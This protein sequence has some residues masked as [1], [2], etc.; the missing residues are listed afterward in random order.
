M[1]GRE[2]LKLFVFLER[3]EISIPVTA[4]TFG[5]VSVRPL[6]WIDYFIFGPLDGS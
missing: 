5:V 2:G 6:F 1:G 4:E 3:R